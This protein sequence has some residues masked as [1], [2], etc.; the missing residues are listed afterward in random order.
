VF[1][2]DPDD[3]DPVVRSTIRRIH[4]KAIEQ[5]DSIDLDDPDDRVE[6]LPPFEEADRVEPAEPRS[7]VGRVRRHFRRS[8]GRSR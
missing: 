6:P 5:L 2:F 4:R 3:T 1:R 8:V 7:T